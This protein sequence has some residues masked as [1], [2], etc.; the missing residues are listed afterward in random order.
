MTNPVRSTR[1]R[2]VCRERIIAADCLREARGRLSGRNRDVDIDI[3]RDLNVTAVFGLH[4]VG[5]KR[6]PV[7]AEPSLVGH[8]LEIAHQAIDRG[9]EPGQEMEE[10]GRHAARDHHVE[11]RVRG[12]SGI[13]GHRPRDD[14]LAAA[15]EP[16]LMLPGTDP[17]RHRHIDDRKR[18]TAHTLTAAEVGL[19]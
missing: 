14:L 13:L 16:G 5:C 11:D 2:M 12:L 10:V 17:R 4:L 15:L 1:A 18:F 8:H 3:D 19:A 7:L 9:Q 6:R